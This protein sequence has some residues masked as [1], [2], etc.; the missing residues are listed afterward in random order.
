MVRHETDFLS[1]T[2]AV[3]FLS[4]GILFLTGEIDP[5]EFVR[6]WAFPV[7]LLGAG[8]VLGALG[9]ARHR[10]LH[11]ATDEAESADQEMHP[12]PGRRP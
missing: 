5:A 8:L 4:I 2:F 9:L 3:L 7:V 11:A 10:R 1:L 12:T 6:V